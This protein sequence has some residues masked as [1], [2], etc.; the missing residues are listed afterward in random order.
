MDVVVVTYNSALVINDAL[1]SIAD[2]VNDRRFSVVVV[3]NSSTDDTVEI[4]RSRDDCLLVRA[5]N[6]GYG[7][8]VNRGV[9]A[10][11]GDGPI[12]V[13]NPDVLLSPGSVAELVRE[14]AHPDVGIVVPRLTGPRDELARSL[15]REPTLARSIGA[16]NSN[17]PRLSEI[18]NEPDAYA[19]T[20]DIE[21]ATGAVMLVRRTCYEALGGFDETFF[22]YSEETD[23]CLRARDRGWRVRYTPR[24]HAVHIGG[25]SGR[26]PD[27]YAMQ[28]LN[29]IRLHRRRHGWSATAALFGLTVAR[30]AVFAARGEPDSR[31]ALAA[32]TRRSQR[33][34]Q[35]PWSG[36]LLKR[37]Y[38]A[39]R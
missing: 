11:C 38:P 3:D 29:R 27:L 19:A 36:G 17:H 1:D 33:P 14:L 18:V 39:A 5:A 6:H 4:V 31:R 20:H 2:A 30:E 32:L 12:L 22:M 37:S 28:V 9:N 26:N 13:A 25:A 7:A 23:F 8:G 10:L 16:G 21:W 24:A 15:R 34:S 35:L